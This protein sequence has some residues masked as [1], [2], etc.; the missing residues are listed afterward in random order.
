MEFPGLQFVSVA[1]CPVTGYCWKETGSIFTA[2]Y[3]YLYK[4]VRSPQAFSFQ[5]EQSHLSAFP[6]MQRF[7]FPNH[8]NGPLLHSLSCTSMTCLF[9]QSPELATALQMCFTRAERAE[10]NNLFWRHS[11]RAGNTLCSAPRDAVGCPSRKGALLAHVQLGV[12]QECQLLSCKA[13]FQLVSPQPV[14]VHG[15]ILH[16]VPD[17]AV[18]CID[19]HWQISPAW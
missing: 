19:S 9:Q 4:L 13:T 12:C 2:S 3:Q 1:S 17:F 16:Q 15:V 8:L 5:A 18:P 11:G 7:Q 14:P 10:G 6:H